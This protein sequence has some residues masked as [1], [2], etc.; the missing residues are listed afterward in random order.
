MSDPK[1]LPKT[2]AEA[3]AKAAALPGSLNERLAAYADYSRHLR[4]E[5]HDAYGRL[6]KRLESLRLGEVGPKVGDPMPDFM[7]PNQRGELVGLESLC[8]DGPVVVSF[9]RGHWCP[10]CRIELRALAAMHRDVRRHGAEIVSIVPDRAQFSKK[11]AVENELPFPVLTDVDL[12][13]ALS[14]GLVFWVGA[15]IKSVYEKLGVDLAVYQGNGNYFLPI[16]ATFVVGRDGL[17]KQRYVDHD[18]RKRMEIKD[19]VATLGELAKR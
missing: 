10:Y 11:M 18:Y 7:L 17:V 12:G 4:P 1:D 8:G 3:F 9:N 13:Y 14:L 5:I 15:E 16:T 19:I 6:V 2:P